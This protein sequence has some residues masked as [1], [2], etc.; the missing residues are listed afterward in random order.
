MEK[1]PE[2]VNSIIRAAKQRF[3]H[4]GFAKVTMEE[5]AS[6]VDLGKASLYYYFPAKEDLFKDVIRSEQNEFVSEIRSLIGRKIK[7]SQKLKEYVDHRLDLFHKL[8]NLGT[9]IFH[10]PLLNNSMCRFL[11][12]EF[13]NTELLLL[14][15]I[16]NEGK[17]S[18][19]FNKEFKG[20]ITKVFLHILQGLR[21]RVLRDINDNQ[22]EKSA[23]TELRKE[24]DIAVEIFISSIKA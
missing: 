24:M 7:A 8:L 19:E 23:L 6:D 4:Y 5:I 11:F 10:S 16:I 21:L 18:G 1:N 12:T 15:E 20:K 9:L 17:K 3:A 22:I 14:D 13:E 2:K